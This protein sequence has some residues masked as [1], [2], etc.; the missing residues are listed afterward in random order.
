MYYETK[1]IE[2]LGEEGW[3]LFCDLN[4]GQQY[5][6]INCPKLAQMIKQ[7]KRLL[8][9]SHEPD[10][11]KVVIHRKANLMYAFIN[12]AEEVSFVEAEI[13]L[14]GTEKTTGKPCTNWFRFIGRNRR[15]IKSQEWNLKEGVEYK[16]ATIKYIKQ[17]K[18]NGLLQG[19]QVHMTLDQTGDIIKAHEVVDPIKKHPENGSIY[20]IYNRYSPSADYH[21][22]QQ[23]PKQTDPFNLWLPI[24]VNFC[25]DRAC[26]P[27]K[28]TSSY[29]YLYP[30]NKIYSN[31]AGIRLSEASPGSHHLK[32][33]S[34][35]MVYT[36]S[37]D[38]EWG[39]TMSQTL[40][41]GKEIFYL[42]AGATFTDKDGTSHDLSVRSVEKPH[43]I[44]WGKDFET[45][46][47]YI[48]WGCIEKDAIMIT[49]DRGPIRAA[50]V[51][52]MDEIQDLNGEYKRVTNIFTGQEEM[53]LFIRAEG[54][55]KGIRVTS[56][57]PIK[58]K[59]GWKQA[60]N[61]NNGDLVLLEGGGYSAIEEIYM[62]PYNDQ[63]FTFE[64]NGSE[65]FFANGYGVGDLFKENGLREEEYKAQRLD[66]ELE[67][68]LKRFLG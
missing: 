31:T 21:Y 14:L 32:P 30:D 64:L 22:T 40:M 49:K 51:R 20:V 46:C 23:R 12:M 66:P 48:L 3:E 34:E 47:I 56:D 2:L 26:T 10:K 53:L 44:N 13:T 61:L 9:L 15:F 37:F 7:Q 28:L 42:D 35:E 52:I 8:K 25:V 58:T 1:T 45:F 39:T 55:D 29:A 5:A 62:D 60:I 38:K 19:G 57:H 43:N 65:G 18:E 4:G 6:E 24:K 27:L 41:E 36:L 16:E 59:E 50:E 68:E 63:V 11:A 54:Q 67:K 17:S 33:T